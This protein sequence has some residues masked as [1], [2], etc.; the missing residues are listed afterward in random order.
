MKVNFSNKIYTNRFLK[1]GLEYAADKGALFAAGTSLV[2]STVA[3]PIAIYTT[4]KTDKENRKLAC[5]KSIASSLVGF[6]VIFGATHPIS[7]G[8]ET[9]NKTPEKYLKP[10][11]VNN[12]KEAGKSLT[13]SKG[14][15]FATQLFKLG[16]G[17]VAAIP[18]SVITCALIP[19][20]MGLIFSQN[21]K[22]TPPKKTEQNN[23]RT[24]NIKTKDIPFT[25]RNYEKLA[26]GMGK[27]IDSDA[28]QNMA[29][30]YKNSNYPMHI[31]AITDITATGAFVVQTNRSK[32]I[33]NSRKAV[34]NN[35]A[36]ISTGI[37]I[38]AGYGIDKLL[39]KP[40]ER[41][42]DNFKIANANSPKLDKYV[43]GIRIAK[44]ALI[45]GTIYYCAIPV[46]S[47]FLAE[48]V[49]KRN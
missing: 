38:G 37:S 22:N 3:R 35:N 9:I 34:L 28:V 48:R 40:T 39:D 2:L 18:K 1:K 10:K 41:F 4:P 8:I 49:G 46:V 25:G 12:L 30:K 26:K 5:A 44:P 29:S 36:M 7:K 6:G 42:I 32:K 24:S 19:P 11:T 43:E 14:Y 27:I 45:L 17:T 31:A 20:I 16:I 21:K 15:Q 33:D 13:A 23:I 47:T